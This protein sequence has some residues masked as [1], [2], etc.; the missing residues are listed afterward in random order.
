MKRL[1]TGFDVTHGFDEDTPGF[2]NGFA[3]VIQPAKL[4]YV[5]SN[6]AE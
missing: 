4:R 5:L 1:L 6:F 2:L 3:C